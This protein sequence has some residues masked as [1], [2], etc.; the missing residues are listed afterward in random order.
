MVEKFG[1]EAKYAFLY[2]DYTWGK[3]VQQSLEKV[4]KESGGKTVLNE[5]TRL[6]EKSYISALLKAKKA[7]PDVL[8]MIHFGN[9]MISSLKQAT[10][11][12]LRE[13]MAIVVPLM[14]LH[15]AHP[16]GPEIMEGVITSMCWYHGLA[17]RFEGSRNFVTLFEE[18]YQKKPGNS[19]ATAWVNIFQYAEV[20]GR[21]IL[22]AMRRREAEVKL[23]DSYNE[24]KLLKER[25]EVENIYLRDQISVQ[26]THKDIIGKSDAM[27]YVLYKIKQVAPSDSTV[28]ILGE[29]G[30]GKE[31][32]AEAIKNE[33]SRRN[34]PL[35]K[36]NCAALPAN[37][38]ESELFGRE[39]GA[40]TGSSARQIGRFELA[41]KGT[42]FLD[43]IG[44]LPL[45][46]QPKLLR[47][48]QSGEFERLGSPNTI[49]VDVRIIAS[50]NRDMLNEVKKGQFR[51]DLYYRLNV[52]PIT[53]PPLRE[54]KEDIPT[55]VKHFLKKF[56]KK[57]G[58]QIEKVP[59]NV[60]K[61][62]QEYR[63]PGNVRELENIIERSMIIS[64]NSILHLA[65]TLETPETGDLR[66]SQHT[67]L[68]EIEHD[69]IIKIL[70][71]TR[72]KIEGKNGAAEFLDI[73]PSTLRTRMRKL[74][75]AKPTQQN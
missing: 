68:T 40:F 65:D 39:K 31:L 12:K 11:L 3:T 49:K 63:W 53:V 26:S 25:L 57:I 54:R 18:R 55:I 70:E 27:K 48:V 24:I 2:A 60:I 69:H 16:L 50:T 71:Q 67:S 62:L 42:I 73:N 32:V 36:V 37:L 61:A 28:L 44:E 33:S 38:I 23:Y 21:I 72:W 13:K 5:S 58:K 14:E 43:E 6:G 15:M 59:Y 35:V 1:K 46:L 41:D 19:A 22:G 29:T 52:F 30:T 7:K 56:A 17:E 64:P 20:I 74:G 9:D 4:I 51:E 34:R 8:V 10:M 75:I 45:E 66:S 47:A